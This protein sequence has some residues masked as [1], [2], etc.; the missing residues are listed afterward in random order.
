MHIVDPWMRWPWVAKYSNVSTIR[1]RGQSVSQ[2]S[3]VRGNDVI[4]GIYDRV[5]ICADMAPGDFFKRRQVGNPLGRNTTLAVSNLAFQ[6]P[7]SIQHD[8]A[9]LPIPITHQLIALW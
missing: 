9:I 4:L 5:G 8:Q 6:T 1:G 3:L 7:L 2:P